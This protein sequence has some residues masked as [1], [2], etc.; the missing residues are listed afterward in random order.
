MGAQILNGD[1]DALRLNADGSMAYGSPY[2]GSS[3]IY[4]DASAPLQGIVVLR[5]GQENR[6]MPLSVEGAFRCVYPETSIHHWDA[7]FVAD[8]TDLCLALLA[9]VPVFMLECLPDEDAVRI[10]QKGLAL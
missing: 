8:A 5:Q 10:L 7:R 4:C 2:A 6:L 1:R 9:Q 3:G